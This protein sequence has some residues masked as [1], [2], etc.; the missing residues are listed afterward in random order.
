[1]FE[2]VLISCVYYCY[3]ML[4]RIC[5]INF[6]FYFS[7]KHFT[8]ASTEIALSLDDFILIAYM[9]QVVASRIDIL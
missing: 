7:F 5:D 8:D 6:T 9:S 3:G 1:M 4:F 2:I